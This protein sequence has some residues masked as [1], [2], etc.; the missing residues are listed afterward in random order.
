MPRRT[1]ILLAVAMA[2]A[3]GGCGTIYNLAP[4]TPT[5][6]GQPERR[7]LWIYG[8]VANDARYGADV[9]SY[10]FTQAEPSQHGA[11]KWMLITGLSTGYATKAWGVDM[12]LSFVTD[13][14]TLPITIPATIKKLSGDDHQPEPNPVPGPKDV[15]ALPSDPLPTS[16]F[17]NRV[18][19]SKEARGLGDG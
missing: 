2:T 3:P 5:K 13:T 6:L 9:I 15:G 8:G 18:L 1:A 4:E 7:P 19:E 11:L 12:P 16:T 17:L 10:P 14:L